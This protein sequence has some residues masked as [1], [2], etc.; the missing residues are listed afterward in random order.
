MLLIPLCFFGLLATEDG[1]LA[2]IPLGRGV[3]L[4]S[5]P[6]QI[7]TARPLCCRISGNRPGIHKS[8]IGEAITLDDAAFC[9]VSSARLPRTGQLAARL[10]F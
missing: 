1:G 4:L 7:R 2:I 6:A 8:D 9:E 3:S 5:A 10:S